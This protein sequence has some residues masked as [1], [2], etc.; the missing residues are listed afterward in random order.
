MREPTQQEGNQLLTESEKGG[1]LDKTGEIQ[2]DE[3]LITVLISVRDMAVKLDMPCLAEEMEVAILVAA[4]EAESRLKKDR[5]ASS[6]K[7][8]A[9]FDLDDQL[10]PVH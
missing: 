10:K 2:M 7:L 8:G 3:W 1:F 4:N 9:G 5:T 6:T